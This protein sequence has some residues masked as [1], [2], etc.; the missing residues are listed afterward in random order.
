MVSNST[1][2]HVGKD[3]NDAG[4]VAF[5]KTWRVIYPCFGERLLNASD[6][7]RIGLQRSWIRGLGLWSAF[8]PDLVKQYSVEMYNPN[9]DKPKYLH[10]GA[11]VPAS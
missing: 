2:V 9:L 1:V 8:L 4:S 5:S 10:L 6:E 3:D 11:E 7:D